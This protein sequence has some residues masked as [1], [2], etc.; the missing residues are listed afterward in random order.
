M[1]AGSIGKQL[2]NWWHLRRISHVAASRTGWA[3]NGSNVWM[4]NR[5]RS[6][7]RQKAQKTSI[8]ASNVGVVSP[9]VRNSVRRRAA[10]GKSLDSYMGE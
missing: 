10:S 8:V 7:D 3:G 1:L 9:L 4:C 2:W 5:V 6:V